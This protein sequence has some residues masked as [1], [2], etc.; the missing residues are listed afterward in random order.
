MFNYSDTQVSIGRFNDVTRIKNGTVTGVLH[1]L[2]VS[3]CICKNHHFCLY[4]Y[5]ATRVVTWLVQRF[6][7]GKFKSHQPNSSLVY[8]TDVFLKYISVGHCSYVSTMKYCKECL[9]REWSWLLHALPWDLKA[10]QLWQ[11]VGQCQNS[12]KKE[13]LS[14]ILLKAKSSCGKGEE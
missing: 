12:L 8:S 3:L 1:C 11:Y 2:S 10:V 5:F 14:K 13:S 7:A 6:S 4:F 9:S